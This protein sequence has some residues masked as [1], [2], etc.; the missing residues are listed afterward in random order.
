MT[1]KYA[2]SSERKMAIKLKVSGATRPNIVRERGWISKF[3]VH[4]FDAG[5]KRKQEPN[6]SGEKR[7]ILKDCG[8][9]KTMG[10]QNKFMHF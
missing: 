10:E 6:R 7:L 3:F 2:N 8:E 5:W 9:I 4:L 1:Q